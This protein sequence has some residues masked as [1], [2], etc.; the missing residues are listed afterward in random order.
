MN[1]PLVEA[2]EKMSKN[3]TISFEPYDMFVFKRMPF[4]L[5]NAPTT[6]QHCM[7]SIFFD[8]AENTIEVFMDG[9]SIVGDLS[10]DF[11]AHLPNALKVL[12]SDWE[13]CYYM[14]KR[15]VLRHMIL[16]RGIKVNKT[17]IEVIEKFPSLISVKGIYSF[18]F[19]R[20]SIGDL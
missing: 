3:R 5:C 12:R 15:I 13:K 18:L 11:L 1:K 8:M 19:I 20:V 16:K 7:M 17:K 9:F 6:S 4:V 2:L 10:N 14:V